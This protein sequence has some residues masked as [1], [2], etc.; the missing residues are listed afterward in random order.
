M[1]KWFGLVVVLFAFYLSRVVAGGLVPVLDPALGS[2]AERISTQFQ[3]RAV[4]YLN[5]LSGR[6]R[7]T[8][9]FPNEQSPFYGVQMNYVNVHRGNLTFAV[10]DLVLLDG[11]PI[12]FGRIYD[13]SKLDG[14][15]FGP[16]WKLS[17]SESIVRVENHLVY[18][19]A[20]NS[21]Y[22]LNVAGNQIRSQHPHLT[23]ISSGHFDGNG[24]Q[25][26][27]NGLTKIFQ[28]KGDTFRL[29]EVQDKNGNAVSLDYEA[30][31]VVRVHSSSGRFVDIRRDARGR[32]EGAQDD[33]GRTV[34][35]RYD[36][37]GF[38]SEV[39]DRAGGS[40]S[41]GYDD[42]GR[43]REIRD[44]RE[45]L[46][47][48]AIHDA[49]GRATRVD[50]Q[51]DSMTFEYAH[52]STT[53][54]NAMQQAAVFWHHASGLTNVVQD[55]AGTLNELSID[56][57]LRVRGLRLDGADIA[58]IEYKGSRPTAVRRIVDGAMTTHNLRY[59]AGGRVVSITDDDGFV[60]R[61]A[62]NANGDVTLVA[63][64]DGWPSLPTSLRHRLPLELV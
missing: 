13:S 30:G 46:N 38:L 21:H 27:S 35:F 41:M 44:P 5:E 2:A 45:I 64:S 63:D 43:L 60:A 14:S 23:G 28:G 54:R 3:D 11:I 55:F 37:H 29:V 17:V 32:V 26:Q 53:V 47:I 40:W 62:Y 22:Q 1:K 59:D 48:A 18:T 42:K 15:D 33:A 34:R 31:V 61:Y 10:R 7:L 58:R 56:D 52:S 8:T 49:D 36:A 9:V 19:D 12:V 16:G 51:H 50:I 39:V 4:N 25:L 20:N 24:L 57:D 6:R